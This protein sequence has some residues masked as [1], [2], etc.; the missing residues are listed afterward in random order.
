MP[1]DN[2]MMYLGTRERMRWVKAAAPGAGF[3]SESYSD[4]IA[5]L[6]GGVGLRNSVGAHMEYDLS[7]GSLTR[8]QVADIENY[9]Y[10]LYGDGLIHFVDPYAMDR[11]LFSIQWSSPK[12]TAEDGIPL[13]GTNRP[14]KVLLNDMSLDYPMYAAQYVVTAG[15]A[16]R[17]FHCPIPSGYTAWV[18][19]HGTAGS[20]GLIVQP[21][22]A[23]SNVGGSTA[24]PVLATNDSTRFSTSVDGTGSLNG[25]DISVDTTTSTT[26]TLAGLMLQLLPTG[27]TPDAGGFISGRGNS[28]CM[29]DGKPKRMPYSLPTESIGMTAKLVE[30]GDW[31]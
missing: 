14:S 10:G 16:A 1:L 8:D 2:G 4:Q 12:I 9:A 27:T 11:N 18:G 25:I 19:A 28:G 5:Y 29:F 24:I 23:G 15:Q 6:S 3:S 22:L 31:L 21:T 20:K 17:K 13:T 30:V 26:I 7:W